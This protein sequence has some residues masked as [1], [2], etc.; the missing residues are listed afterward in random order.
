MFLRHRVDAAIGPALLQY[1]CHCDDCQT[2][3]GKAFGL[4]PF[5]AAAVS[6]LRGNTEVYVLR[7]SPRTKCKHCATF[8]FAEVAGFRGVNGDLLPAGT[9]RPEFH[10]QCRYAPAPIC[11]ALPHY[12]GRPARF[13][14]SDELMSW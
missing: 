7:S 12:K 1:Y 10:I 8:L 11:D 14:G 5:S 2:V 4:S 13:C 9:F 3:H 6:V